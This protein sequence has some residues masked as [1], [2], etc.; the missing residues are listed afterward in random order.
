MPRTNQAWL[1][2]IAC[3]AQYIAEFTAGLSFADYAKDEKTQAAV[4][5]QFIIIGEALTQLEQQSPDTAASI[6]GRREI[7]GMRTALTHRFYEVEAQATWDIIINR[8]PL[9]RAEVRQLLNSAAA[10]P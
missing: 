1:Q 5:R 4:E 10:E 3:A 9:L 2:S 6:S 7:I 8:L